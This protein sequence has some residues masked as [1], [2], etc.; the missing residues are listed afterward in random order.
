[1][2]RDSQYCV[3][4]VGPFSINI[5]IA[6]LVQLGWRIDVARGQTVAA[7]YGEGAEFSAIICCLN[8]GNNSRVILRVENNGAQS[9]CACRR[10]IGRLL[11][12]LAVP[13]KEL[14]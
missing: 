1:M 4:F 2:S 12:A 7:S 10:E 5:V 6:C 8:H 9:E 13:C 3:S 14:G 11:E